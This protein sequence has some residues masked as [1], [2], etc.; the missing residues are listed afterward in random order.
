[1]ELPEAMFGINRQFKMFSAKQQKKKT[2]END[3]AS[4]SILPIR[5]EEWNEM[6]ACAPRIIDSFV[7]LS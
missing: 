5:E 4:C 1:M 6:W 2:D 3:K 7:H